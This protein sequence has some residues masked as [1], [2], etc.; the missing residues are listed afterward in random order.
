MATASTAEQGLGN[1]TRERADTMASILEQGAGET[2]AMRAMLMSARNWQANLQESNRSYF[3]SLQT[4]NQGIGDL[5]IDTRNAMS[6]AF[7]SSE[8]E[9]DRLWQD[10]YNKRSETYTQLGNVQGQR[11][12]Y[13]AQAKE[14]GVKPKKGQESKA[15]KEMA[16][17]YMAGSKE[18]GKSY[19]Q[20]KLPDWAAKFA[21]QADVK[22][23]QAN[24]NLAAAVE[25]GDVKKAEGSTLKK[26]AKA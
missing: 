6:N 9:K 18:A 22:A 20:Q 17:A 4:V 21:G 1:R 10:F 11:A 8:G 7:T 13:M 2:D 25:L 23:K 5:N 19:V 14:M 24:T 12:D 16:S 3:D 15:Q 26:W